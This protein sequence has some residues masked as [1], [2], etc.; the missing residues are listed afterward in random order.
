MR[1][2]VQR[3]AFVATC[4][5]VLAGAAQA[6]TMKALDDGELADVRGANGVAFN[7]V[8]FSLSGP[9]SIT[10]TSPDGSSLSLGNLSLSRSDDLDTTFSDPYTLK[11]INRGNGLADAIRLTEPANANGALK[12]QFAA[13]WN[14]QADGI[15]HQGGA[16]VINDLVS[17]AGSVT[18]TTPATP[19]VEGIAFGLGLNL[20]IGDVLLR[21]RGR[22]D[23]TEQLQFHGIHLGAAAED[24]TLLGT[25]WLLA[26]ATH[27]PGILNAVTDPDGTSYLHLGIGWPTTQAGA[28]IGSLVIDNISFKTDA[29]GGASMDLG[30]SRIGTMQIQYMDVKLRPGM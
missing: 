19:G 4:A 5:A 22:A 16:L 20:Q 6:D 14:I 25:P 8:N 21:P 7:L 11:V 18:L 1:A 2:A 15:D 29:L 12:W 23:G 26:D 17:R 10:Y 30:S 28:P 3:I 9:L 24:G 27:Q 13:D